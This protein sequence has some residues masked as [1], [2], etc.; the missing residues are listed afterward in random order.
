MLDSATQSLV[1]NMV[2]DYVQ[3]MTGITTEVTE[4]GNV[5][6]DKKFAGTSNLNIDTDSHPEKFI[7]CITD[8]DDP[9]WIAEE[10][11][12]DLDKMVDRIKQINEYSEEV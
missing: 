2:A 5:W 11:P 7:L 10:T 8:D 4:P 9:S 12:I 6:L 3:T 1:D